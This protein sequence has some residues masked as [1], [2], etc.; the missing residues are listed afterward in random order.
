M[1]VKALLQA[2]I[3]G[4][5]THGPSVMLKACVLS[6]T[7]RCLDQDVPTNCRMLAVDNGMALDEG[8][9]GQGNSSA[10]SEQAGQ[11]LQWGTAPA[12]PFTISPTKKKSTVS[13]AVKD[14]QV[15][16]A[17]SA[18]CCHT[19]RGQDVTVASHPCLTSTS[20]P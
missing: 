4:H 3:M 19:N 11:G 6:M 16:H 10:G 1:V 17:T 7:H 9:A 5:L 13:K 2:L 15:R 14:A 12:A 20:C 18:V 8:Q